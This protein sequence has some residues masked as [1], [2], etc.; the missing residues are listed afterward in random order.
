MGFL[1]LNGILRISL[2]TLV[3][4]FSA[5]ALNAQPTTTDRDTHN[6]R[7]VNRD[8]YDNRD[9]HH[10]WGWIGLLGLLGLAGLVP[11]KRDYDHVDRNDRTPR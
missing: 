8:H 6:E 1:K 2:L 11:K 4:G 9:D 5:Q 10:N 7:T 3:L